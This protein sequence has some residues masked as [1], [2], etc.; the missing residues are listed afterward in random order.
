MCSENKAKAADLYDR[1]KDRKH[2]VCQKSNSSN[3]SLP[4]NWM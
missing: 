3:S 2:E 1:E 4:T